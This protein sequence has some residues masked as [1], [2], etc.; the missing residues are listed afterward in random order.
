[1]AAIDFNLRLEGQHAAH[2]LH[3]HVTRRLVTKLFAPTLE[4][5]LTVES[6]ELGQ[7]CSRHRHRRDY[8][9]DATS[10]GAV[11]LVCIGVISR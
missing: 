9:H 7:R 11:T 1:M 8:V 5:S 6:L 3:R 10:S 2:E 4:A